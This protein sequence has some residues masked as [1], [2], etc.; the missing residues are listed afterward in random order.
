MAKD[1]TGEEGINNFG[2]IIKIKK[3][4]NYKDIDINFPEYNWTAEHR[5]YNDFKKGKVKCPYEK[6]F[7]GI[8]FLGEGNYRISDNGIPNKIY[9]V[10]RDMLKRCYVPDFHKKHPTYKNCTVYNEWHNFQNFA[11]WYEENYYEVGNEKM[12]LDKD[13][14]IKGNKIYSPDTCIFVPQNINLLFVKCDST[15][16]EYPI[17]VSYNK[18]RKKFRSRCR[19]NGKEV[20]IG[21]YDT[22]EE[23]FLAYKEFKEHYIKQIA[24]EYIDLIPSTLYQAMITY[25][26]NYND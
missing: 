2:S 6:R 21:Y 4:R 24:D 15:R 18:S 1:K 13:I 10:W 23:A 19:V 9:R 20:V 16:G 17:G 26:I 25:E 22:T 8:G 12:S 11:E 5:E 3:Y 7:Y 14:L